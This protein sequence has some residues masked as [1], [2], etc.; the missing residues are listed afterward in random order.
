MYFNFNITLVGFGFEIKIGNY[1]RL[2]SLF[3]TVLYFIG[4]DKTIIRMDNPI[5][6]TDLTLITLIKLAG[7]VGILPL[8]DILAMEFHVAVAK[9]YID[10]IEGPAVKMCLEWSNGAYRWR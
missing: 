9:G 10:R 8:H 7:L 5:G 4:M 2:F 3:Y 6:A 1:F